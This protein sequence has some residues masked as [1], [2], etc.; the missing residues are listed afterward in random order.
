M[1]STN[2]NQHQMLLCP[3]LCLPHNIERTHNYNR[4]SKGGLC[5]YVVDAFCSNAVKADGQ[6]LP[7]VD[8][9]L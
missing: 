6:C 4:K 8:L 7:D 2:I 3:H 1:E 9:F 5:V